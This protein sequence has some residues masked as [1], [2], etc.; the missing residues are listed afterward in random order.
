MAR[1][2]P[3]RPAAPKQKG[4]PPTNPELYEPLGVDPKALLAAVLRPPKNPPAK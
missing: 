2:R 4:R 3:K 1:K